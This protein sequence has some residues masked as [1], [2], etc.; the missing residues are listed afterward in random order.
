MKR[1]GWLLQILYGAPQHPSHSHPVSRGIVVEGY[2]NLHH[3]LK[4]LLILRRRSA[5]DVFEGFV[6]IEEL[7]VVEQADSTLILIGIHALFL[8]SGV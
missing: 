7:G 5:P 2:G 1:A 8:H 3:S 4:K 6:S